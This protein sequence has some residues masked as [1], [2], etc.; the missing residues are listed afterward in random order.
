MTRKPRRRVQTASKKRTVSKSKSARKTNIAPPRTDEL[1]T[2]IA[3]AAK[4][5][6]LPTRKAWLPVIKANLKVTLQLA[7]VVTAFEL[8]GRCRA[9]PRVPGLNLWRRAILDFAFAVLCRDR[10]CSKC[11]RHHRNGGDRSR[12]HPHQED[13][14]GAQRLH[15][16]NGEASPCA[17]EGTRRE[18][19]G[20]GADRP[21]RGR[22][23]CCEKSVR[24][25]RSC[26]AGRIENQP[27]PSAI[28][29]ET[30]R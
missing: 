23:V 3:A 2:F 11:W 10:A 22:A 1:D 12:A 25:Y 7:S 4:A 5:L 19:R 18:T 8:P 9:G 21:A 13:Q 16:C 28:E 17:S 26:D 29:A 24:R 20:W 14:S 27:R 15:R 30:R 6:D